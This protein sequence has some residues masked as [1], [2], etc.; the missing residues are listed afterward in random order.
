MAGAMLVLGECIYTHSDKLYNMKMQKFAID[1]DLDAFLMCI[2][3]SVFFYHL[4]F[5]LSSSFITLSYFDNQ[6]MKH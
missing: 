1:L 6:C 2:H 5:R 3:T 4:H